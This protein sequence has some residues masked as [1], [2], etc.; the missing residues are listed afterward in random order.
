[1]LLSA[2]QEHTFFYGLLCQTEIIVDN[3]L[4]HWMFLNNPYSALLY[5]HCRMC[6]MWFWPSWFFLVYIMCD[7]W[8]SMHIRLFCRVRTCCW[9]SE[10]IIRCFPLYIL[11]WINLLP[12][13]IRNSCNRTWKN[14]TSLFGHM[15][16]IVPIA[17]LRVNH[18]CFRLGYVFFFFFFRFN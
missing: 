2:K 16:I 13:L 7:I 10:L 14:P 3:W 9:L 18:W 5:I 8:E 12:Y 11:A 15:A 4:L 6:R 1:M 17:G